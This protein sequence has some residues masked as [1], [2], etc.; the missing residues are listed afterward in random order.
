MSIAING[1]R[2]ASLLAVKRGV[3]QIFPGSVQASSDSGITERRSEMLI[4]SDRLIGCYSHWEG[5]E[6]SKELYKEKM[7][8]TYSPRLASSRC[9]SRLIFS[10]IHQHYTQVCAA[11]S[12]GEK[13]LI[14][15]QSDRCAP[16]NEKLSTEHIYLYMFCLVFYFIFILSLF[17][18]PWRSMCLCECIQHTRLLGRVKR[19][20]SRS[21]STL[22]S[23]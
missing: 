19:R 1:K 9:R 17:G 10:S 16:H 7:L 11:K 4:D 14:V 5:E 20:I 8:K 3:E 13:A 23:I 6:Y 18:S 21:P 22:F 2:L 15:Y 12:D